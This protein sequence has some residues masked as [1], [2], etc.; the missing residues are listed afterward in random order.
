MD[1]ADSQKSTGNTV[2]AR[3]VGCSTYSPPCPIQLNSQTAHVID[4]WRVTRTDEAPGRQQDAGV[5]E[6]KQGQT[7]WFKVRGSPINISGFR[8]MATEPA[9]SDHPASSRDLC[10]R[11]SIV[12]TI[13][14]REK[15]I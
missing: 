1:R 11:I 7:S 14:F 13:M 15:V 10:S 6:Q 9:I 2:C 8:R 12:G 4:V 3:R 5:T